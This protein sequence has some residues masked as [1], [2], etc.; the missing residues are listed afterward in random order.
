MRFDVEPALLTGIGQIAHAIAVAEGYF[1]PGSLPL[2]YNN[3][4]DI[5]DATGSKIQF[6]TAEAGWARLYHQIELIV[7]GRS[8]VYDRQMTLAE[9][10]QKWTGGDQA[11]AWANNVARVL[12]IKPSDTL[13]FYLAGVNPVPPT[14]PTTA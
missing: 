1:A 6:P 13:A 3:P 10:A 7:S 8:R 5:E 12:G 14:P 2:R 4:G 11:R 9:I